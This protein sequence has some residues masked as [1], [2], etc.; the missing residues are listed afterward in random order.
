M[1]TCHSCGVEKGLYHKQGCENEVCNVCPSEKRFC[2]C[3]S[4]IKIPFGFEPNF[5]AKYKIQ[6]KSVATIRCAQGTT[7]LHGGHAVEGCFEEFKVTLDDLQVYYYCSVDEFHEEGCYSTKFIKT[8]CLHCGFILYPEWQLDESI[9]KM[10]YDN[11]DRED[12]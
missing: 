11:N 4:E 1:I 7:G 12:K 8:P 2:E 3:S 10:A 6:S 5:E 9:I